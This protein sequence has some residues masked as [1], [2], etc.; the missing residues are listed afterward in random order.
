MLSLDTLLIF[1]LTALIVIV[2]IQLLRGKWLTLIAGYNTMSKEKRATI[3]GKNLGKLV[4]SLLIW[5]NVLII[6]S[7]FFPAISLAAVI[8]SLISLG[9]VPIY[10]NTS[11]KFKS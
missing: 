5:I 2:G 7:Y 1:L 4:G 11:K 9:F 6:F 10:A 3:N 8:L